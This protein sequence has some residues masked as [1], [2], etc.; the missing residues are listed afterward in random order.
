MAEAARPSLAVL[1]DLGLTPSAIADLVAEAARVGAPAEEIAFARRW[2][3]PARYYRALGARLGLAFVDPRALRLR[4]DAPGFDPATAAQR[5]VA[6]IEGFGRVRFCVAPRGRDIDR[7]FALAGDPSI[8]ASFAVACPRMLGEAL[9]AQAGPRILAGAIDALSAI[10]PALSAADTP[11]RVGRLAMV[12]PIVLALVAAGATL[13]PMAFAFAAGLMAVLTCGT[14]GAV[15]A[16]RALAFATKAPP[17]PPLLHDR[18]LPRVTL[19]IAAYREAPVMAQLVAGLREIDYPAAKLDI[20]LLLEADDPQTAA[21]LAAADP[22]G[23]VAVLVVPPGAPRTK[24]RALQYGLTFARGEIVGVYDAEDIPHPAQLR[25]MAAAFA[26][27]GDGLA[28]VQAPLV[29]EGARAGFLETHFALEYAALFHVIVPGLAARGLPVMLG[30][31]SNFFRADVL[32]ALGGWDPWNVTE[33]ADLGLRLF[34]AG[35]SVATVTPP[36]REEAPSRWPV[37]RR[38]RL[39]WQ[40]GWMQTALVHV[41]D[42]V[43]LARERGVLGAGALLATL[44]GVIGVG[45][46]YPASWCVLLAHVALGHP[47][48]NDPLIA[49]A[50][51]SGACLFALGHGVAWACLARGATFGRSPVAPTVF[52]GATAYW[53]LVSVAAWCAVI[54]LVRRPFHWAKTDHVGLY[55]IARRRAAARSG[56][57]DRSSVETK[58]PARSST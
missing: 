34:R 13:A 39:R 16:I 25:A 53:C 54:D 4:L 47:V 21:A 30:G 28:C 33:D 29:V 40:K 32:R 18:D 22:D 52:L 42:P 20:L 37:W 7:L 27:G 36:T 51:W 23:R 48:S 56:P 1:V 41:A 35:Y 14:I 10:D 6:P 45:L 17:A 5:R 3:T 58:R 38:Q 9:A 8:A 46:L 2:V 12:L 31:T 57:A 49:G 43:R 24:P 26:R 55:N 19:L 11:R 15:V 44:A 50:F